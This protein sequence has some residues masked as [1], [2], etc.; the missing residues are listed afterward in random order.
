MSIFEYD[1]EK[2]MRQ[3]REAAWEEG[4]KEGHRAGV[5]EGRK[6]GHRAGVDE[7]HRAGL[8]EGEEQMLRKLV[9]RKLKKAG[10]WRRQS[11]LLSGSNVSV[12]SEFLPHSG[13][14]H[15]TLPLVLPTV[16]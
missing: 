7:G 8:A 5:E 2:H 13:Y 10:L 14:L 9:E 3:E 11:V 6:E 4:R 15:W 12:V 16:R 1:Q